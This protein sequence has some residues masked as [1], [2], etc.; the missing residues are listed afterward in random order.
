MAKRYFE[1]KDAKSKKFWEV[2]VSGKKV[3][4]RY[5]K[6]GT[7]GQTS[8]KELGTPAEAKAH[9]EKQAAG[10]VKKGYKEAKVKAVKKVA[11]KKAVKKKAVKKK[12]VKKKA[13][14]KKATKKATKKAPAKGKADQV[15]QK[16]RKAIL[17]KIKEEGWS[18]LEYADKSLKADREIVLKAVKQYGENLQYAAKNL[19][20]DREIVF[21]AVKQVYYALQYAAKSLKADREI[22]LA[23]VKQD[24]RALEYAD[25][26]LK[27]DREIVLKAV[28]DHR[29]ALEYADK[30]LKADREFMLECIKKF[31]YRC[32]ALEY[33]DKNLKA[34]RE[35]VFA[36]V[37]K[38]SYWLEYAAKNLKADRELV[39]KAVKD[40]GGALE[41]A[42][43]SLKA[44]R[45]VVLAAVKTY[46]GALEHAG[47]SLKADREVVFA[48]VKQDADALQYA[49]KNLKAELLAAGDVEESTKPTRIYSKTEPAGEI[50]AGKLDDSEVSLLRELFLKDSL[51]DSE[52]V[53]YAH[54]KDNIGHTYG[55]LTDK[56]GSEVENMEVDEDNMPEYNVHSEIS[57]STEV[58]G[59][60]IVFTGLSKISA[61]FEFSPDDGEPF[62]PSKMTF[63]VT[64]VDLGMVS[65]SLYGDLEFSVIDG[66][67]YN[68][69]EIE[70]ASDDIYVDRGIDRE[71][72]IIHVK[73]EEAHEIYKVRHESEEIYSVNGLTNFAASLAETGDKEWAKKVYEK[74]LEVAEKNEDEDEIEEIKEALEELG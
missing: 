61:G 31:G 32:S 42:A 52:L 14:K 27:A 62:D 73:N 4:I 50:S 69:N 66:Y 5:G 57:I 2:S 23:A 16:A 30:S 9:A 29:R 63:N 56:D 22:V 13:T 26:S 28:K 36:A 70:E 10:K 18:A 46:G 21:A 72:T 74:A 7:D 35:F 37:K 25:K 60:Y 17:K 53:E 34:D 15:D 47:K 33:A 8:L 58:D 55:V 12:A 67:L 6:L 40:Y 51:K 43:K 59:F 38:V 71:A 48:A 49:D 65:D 39:L 11:K 20:A 68:G 54:E 41:Y 19:K 24:G 64:D 45:E 1:Y 44:D 3:N